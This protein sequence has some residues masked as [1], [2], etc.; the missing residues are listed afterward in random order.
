MPPLHK[1]TNQSI[2][3]PIHPTMQPSIQRPTTG[4]PR[5]SPVSQEL[6]TQH[7]QQKLPRHVPLCRCNVAQELCVLNGDVATTDDIQTTRIRG[8]S[9]SNKHT[10]RKL[11]DVVVGPQPELKGGQP[12]VCTAV[13][14]VQVG[15]VVLRSLRCCHCHTQSNQS[16]TPERGLGPRSRDATPRS[17]A[18]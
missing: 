8:G 1:P 5:Q 4:Y 7:S 17:R 10:A 18:A 3:P 12:N 14:V 16:T 2:N 9:V 13:G 11:D 6:S 15:R